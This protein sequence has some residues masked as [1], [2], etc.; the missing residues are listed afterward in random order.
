ML[1]YILLLQQGFVLAGER[2]RGGSPS[3]DVPA[4]SGLQGAF[5][6]VASRPPVD[7]RERL[8]RV[9]SGEGK[10][11][12]GLPQETG[13]R[14]AEGQRVPENPSQGRGA[15]GAL[16]S[17]CPH[18]ALGRGGDGREEPSPPPLHSPGITVQVIAR[19]SLWD[20]APFLP[21]CLGT[22]STSPYRKW[23]FV[24]DGTG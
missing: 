8:V 23:D 19:R 4:W 16:R 9:S 24:W 10:A 11:Q 18:P 1:G 6:V 21:G 3:G 14:R 15:A 2:E 12:G 22:V 17:A 13:A 20:A 5:R 7:T